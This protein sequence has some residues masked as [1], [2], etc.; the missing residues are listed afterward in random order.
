MWWFAAS[1]CFGLWTLLDAKNRR[2]KRMVL[3]VLVFIFGPI[4]I[5]VHIA[6][7][8]LRD[9]EVREGGRAWNILKNFALYWT[10]TCGVGLVFGL[11][12]AGGI[13]SPDEY[14]AAGVAIGTGLSVLFIGMLWFF[15]T[16]SALI[17]GLFLKKSSF[18]EKGPT[19]E[20]VEQAPGTYT[21]KSL[22]AD[23]VSLGRNG[24]NKTKQ[25]K[26][27]GGFDKIREGVGRIAHAGREAAS[28]TVDKVKGLSPD[29]HDR[30]E[31]SGPNTEHDSYDRLEKLS[32]LKAKGILTDEEFAAQKR[33]ILESRD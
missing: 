31:E 32:E 26:V 13:E 4:L 12:A 5:P 1:I 9:G 19:G 10:I 15:V 22:M 28:K 16:L 23:L 17:L 11:A 29:W 8:N 14:H 2:Q 24:M 33:K 6:T 30:P 20:L 3:P 7:R 21:L 25:Y 27:E 18:V